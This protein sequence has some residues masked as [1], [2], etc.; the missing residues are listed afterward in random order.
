MIGPEVVRALLERLKS[1]EQSQVRFR[2]GQ[3]TGTGPLSVTLGGAGTPYDNVRAIDAGALSVDDYVAALTFGNDL[4][5]LGRIGVGGDPWHEVG[6]VAQPAFSGTWGNLGGGR[7]TA[8]FRL[9]APRL[10]AIKGEVT[11]GTPNST[12]FTLPAGLRPP[13]DRRI[14]TMIYN[15]GLQPA[16]VVVTAAG[17]VSVFSSATPG[18]VYINVMVP[19]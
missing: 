8:G 11:G 2:K 19:L 16:V 6:A 13:H 12:I 5:V 18:E 10:L 1:L 9:A 3:V 15:G 17:A 4:I 7:E 14:A